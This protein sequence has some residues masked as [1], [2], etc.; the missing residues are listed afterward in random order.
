MPWGPSDSIQDAQALT[1]SDTTVINTTRSVWVGGTGDIT[2]TMLSGNTALFS[3][4]PAGTW[5][6]IQITKLQATGTTAT[7]VLGLY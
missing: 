7:N 1:K 2:V 6:P 4:V 5:M 3:S